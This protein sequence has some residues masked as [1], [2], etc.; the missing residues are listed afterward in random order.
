MPHSLRS[1]GP[2]HPVQLFHVVEQFT[3]TLTHT[4]KL[5]YCRQYSVS[6]AAYAANESV[7][8]C[9]T[10]QKMCLPSQSSHITHM[11]TCTLRIITHTH[12]NTVAVLRLKQRHVRGCNK[13][14]Q[15]ITDM[16]IDCGANNRTTCV[17]TE[18]VYR[19][20]M[21]TRLAQG[22]LLHD[23]HTATQPTTGEHVHVV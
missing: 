7:L 15:L 6:R 16:Y 17:E 3:H 4:H 14:V 22:R 8:K 10:S 21:K 2:K 11:H 23:M 5:N 13:H 9:N 19:S 12:T 1:S 18:H 20:Y